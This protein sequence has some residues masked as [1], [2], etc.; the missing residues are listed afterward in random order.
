MK[1]VPLKADYDK[2]YNNPDKTKQDRYQAWIKDLAKDFHLN[3][4]ST[5]LSAFN[6]KTTVAK[7]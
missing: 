7:K 6:K 3:E 1:L 4:S 2:F 5:I